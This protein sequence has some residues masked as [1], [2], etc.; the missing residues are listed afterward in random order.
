[1]SIEQIIEL[2]L[3]HGS[4][5]LFA[6]YLIFES[7]RLRK[8]QAETVE[9]FTAALE[10]LRGDSSST[11]SGLRLRYDGVIAQ[12]QKEKEQAKEGL[13]DKVRALAVRL[14]ELEKKT[15]MILIQLESIN[16]TISELKL[17]EIARSTK[18]T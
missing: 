4:L 10:K 5:G 17:R 12:L 18:G 15:E 11:E 14:A 7:H 13:L 3:Q 1:M 2:L 9:H 16:G 8:Q 6:A